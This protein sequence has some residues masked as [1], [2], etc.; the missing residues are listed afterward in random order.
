[1][2]ERALHKELCAK[3]YSRLFLELGKKKGIGRR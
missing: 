3:K 1:M 2:S